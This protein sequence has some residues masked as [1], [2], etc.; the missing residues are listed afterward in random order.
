M[1][2]VMVVVVVVVV[3]VLI[4]EVRHVLNDYYLDLVAEAMGEY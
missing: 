2:V 1:V 3:V 4:K